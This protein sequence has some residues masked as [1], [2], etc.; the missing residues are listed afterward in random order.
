[1]QS[2]DGIKDIASVHLSHLLSNGVTNS[3]NFAIS[4]SNAIISSISC[5]A[6]NTMKVVFRTIFKVRITTNAIEMVS[7]TF[8]WITRKKSTSNEIANCQVIY[9]IA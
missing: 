8:E 9:E 7:T 5:I 4:F 6:A 2:I 1:M 3:T